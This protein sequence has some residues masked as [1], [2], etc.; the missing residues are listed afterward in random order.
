MEAIA[1][2]LF[3][4]R[5][6]LAVVVMGLCI[7]LFRRYRQVG[8]LVLAAA[9]L[10]PFIHVLMSAV[11]GK[12]LLTYRA[13]GSVVNGA[14]QVKYRLELPV[15]YVVVATALLLLLWEVRHRR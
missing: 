12:P 5:F 7:M 1:A 2:I 3:Y 14:M 11:Q 6:V 13:L 9:F 10:E 8:W 15:F 4:S